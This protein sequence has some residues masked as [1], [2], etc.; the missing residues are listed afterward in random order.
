MKQDETEK[1]KTAEARD[2]AEHWLWHH[3]Q[4]DADAIVRMA[5]ELAAGV[6][7]DGHFRERVFTMMKIAVRR[8]Q[9]NVMEHWTRGGGTLC[10]CIGGGKCDGGER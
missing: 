8:G 3:T 4:S 6:N 10:P 9:S 1:Q 5:R 7:D 2:D